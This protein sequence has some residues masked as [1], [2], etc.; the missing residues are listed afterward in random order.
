MVVTKLRWPSPS[1]REGWS[2]QE[3]AEFFRIS[4]FMEQAGLS[5]EL[6]KG[7][8]DEETHGWSSSG[9]IPGM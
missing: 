8:T 9:V 7:V 1:K 3:T 6:E 5:V 2:N 4:H